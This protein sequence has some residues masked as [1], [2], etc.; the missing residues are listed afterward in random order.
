MNQATKQVNSSSDTF[1][2]YAG[3]IWFKCKAVLVV[4]I[5]FQDPRIKTLLISAVMQAAVAV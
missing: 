5:S 2:L 1:E 3:G 4:L